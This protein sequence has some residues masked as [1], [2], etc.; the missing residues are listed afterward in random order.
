MDSFVINKINEIRNR[1]EELDSALN[2]GFNEVSMLKEHKKYKS[3]LEIY[4]NYLSTSKYLDE[5]REMISNSSDLDFKLQCE[6]EYEHIK[7]DVEKYESE[8]TAALTTKD[9]NDDCNAIFE[10]SGEVGGEEANLFARDLFCM[11]VKYAQ[12]AGFI[13]DVL[14]YDETDKKGINYASFKIIGDGAYG[15]FKFESGIH[16]VQRVPETEAKGR[17]HTSTASVMVT[18][19]VEVD[20]FELNLD[21]VDITT[22][23]ASGAGGQHIN[24]TSSAIR[25]TY[26]PTGLTVFCQSRRSQGQNKDEALRIL[27]SRL[28]AE[29]EEKEAAA[30]SENKSSKLGTR[31]RSEKIRTYNYSENRLT[32]HRINY[33]SNSLD[34]IL[35]GDLEEL[36]HA[37]S[38]ASRE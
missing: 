19:E 33:K 25:A 24:K 21:D 12:S 18:P 22:C 2:C 15:V 36:L 7:S 26:K 17:I 10:I 30:S 8:L 5:M 29:K 23:H 27:A 38:I 11:Y 4:D 16:R 14:E 31:N 35:Q 3:I 13:V 37:L 34:K 32:D 9:K 1:F 28:K 6:D 20:A